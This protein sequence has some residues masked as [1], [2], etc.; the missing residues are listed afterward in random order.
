MDRIWK[1]RHWDDPEVV[2]AVSGGLAGA[3]TAT[4][5]CPLDVLK[6]RLQV[7][8]TASVQYVGITGGLSKILHEE[9]F[10]GLYR[11]LSPTLFALLPNWAVY[12]T[13]YE[14]LKVTFTERAAES[15]RNIPAPTIHMASASAAGVATLV[16]TNP[17]WVVKT[18]LQTQHMGLHMGRR[19]NGAMYKGTFDALYRIAREEGLAGLYSGLAPSLMGVC[20]VAIQFPLYEYTKKWMA[21]RNGPDGRKSDNLSATQLVCASAFSK[22]V[23]STATYPHEVVRSHMHV[24]GSGPF[25]GL[26]S[27]CKEIVRHD[28]FRGLYRGCAANLF[29]QVPSAA[30]TITS[31]EL[32]ARYIRER[33][34]Q[35]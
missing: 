22:M 18:R 5:I 8:R 29:Q 19:P 1:K 6:T 35:R 10:R 26:A 30:L 13:V 7:Q 20:H 16:F 31:F 25:N 17:L 15:G 34:E 9:G 32:I 14:R 11:G 3:L 21:Q 23:A 24:Q 27:T 4:F 33:A 12:F 28:G 2:S